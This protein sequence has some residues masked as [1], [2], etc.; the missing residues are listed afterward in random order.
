M[1]DGR[2]RANVDRQRAAEAQELPPEAVYW[3]RRQALR[4]VRLFASI[5]VGL[6]FVLFMGWTIEALDEPT[7]F[8]FE[9]AAATHPA[10]PEPWTPSEGIDREVVESIDFEQ[11]HARLLPDWV[12]SLQHDPYTLGQSRELRR[13]EALMQEA[14]KDPNLESL[15]RELRDGATSGV[16]AH[17]REISQLLDGWNEYMQE[18]HLPWYIA[19]DLLKTARGGRLYTRSYRV[20][21]DI[22][23]T[24][25][26]QPQHVRLLVRVDTTNVGELFFGQTNVDERRAMVVTDRIAEFALDRV[27]PM[28]DPSSDHRLD[29]MDR[30][31]APSLRREAATVLAPDVVA[32]LELGAATRRALQGRLNEIAVRKGCGRG[33]EVDNLPWNGLTPRGRSIVARAVAHNV[34]TKCKRLTQEDARL[35]IG[36]SDALSQDEQLH[37][38]L[39][40]LTAWLARAVSVH[41]VRHLADGP[42]APTLACDGCPAEVSK[43]G[44]A[45]VS[46]YVASMATEGVGYL[47]LYQACGVDLPV[48]HDSGGALDFVLSVLA[49][50]GCAAGPPSRLYEQA[51]VLDWILFKRAERIALPANFPEVLPLPSVR[52]APPEPGFE[53]LAGGPLRTRHPAHAAFPMRALL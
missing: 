10:R 49:P 3:S 1:R 34:Q 47:A 24:V 18:A 29:A 43:H 36:D 21:A 8:D 20:H 38:A 37:R 16:T 9:I 19:Y 42:A 28:M 27:W 14:G 22:A 17:A 30:A 46:A 50:R 4:P 39:G 51:R 26:G 32:S 53:V 44:G 40:Q 15:L 23:P 12:I 13:F 45:E 7:K 11:V 41:E 33:I 2:N 48:A 31:F 35:L 6:A 52:S 25:S 5:L